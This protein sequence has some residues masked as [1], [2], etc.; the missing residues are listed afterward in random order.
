M[1]FEGNK[2]KG[3]QMKKRSIFSVVALLILL[4]CCSNICL[5]QENNNDW[6][7]TVLITNDDGI[8]DNN[9]QRLA[10]AFSKV[11]E[12]YVVAPLEDRSGSTHYSTVFRERAVK[13]E[14]R[15][16][17]EGIHAFGVDG[18]PADCVLFALRGIMRDN[19][20]DLVISGINDGP[21][22]AYDWIFSGTIG[23][24]RMAT[25]WGVPAI[26][27]SGL[28]DTIPG[29][30]DAATE[31][32]V[33]LAQSQIVRDLK[34]PEYL[35][36]SIPRIPPSK[37]KGV[38][39]VERAGLLFDCVFNKTTDST[40]DIWK[41]EF[42]HRGSAP[43]NSDVVLYHSGYVVLVPMQANENDYELLS[44]LKEQSK[45][46]PDWSAPNNKNK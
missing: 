17:G 31:W 4:L 14:P 29:A 9:I 10:S 1:V 7:R 11:A 28:D 38:R 30:V 20:P 27:I 41:L 3:G 8:D 21:N 16:L 37:I 40:D 13:V 5:A 19:P 25:F 34:P 44:H 32:V 43:E 12:T 46:L 39:V 22:L 42:R 33:R 6:P 15:K 35:T 23:A 24:A 45:T 26:A 18:F 2:L 36:V